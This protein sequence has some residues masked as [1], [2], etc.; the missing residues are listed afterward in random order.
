MEITGKMV[1]AKYVKILDMSIG[2]I[3]FQTDKRLAVGGR[4]TL[5]IES[6]GRILTAQGIVA[7]SL[8][9]QGI[10]DTQENIVPIYTAGMKF[11]DGT[12]EQVKEIANFIED[13]KRES[14]KQVDLFSPSGLRL[15]V[16]IH[17]EDPEMATLNLQE[18]YNVHNLSF[19]GMLI[20]SQN[21]LKIESKLPME[22]ILNE[23]KAIN[24]SGRV[25]SCRLITK[26]DIALYH[27]GIEFL[28]MSEKD[29]GILSEIIKLLDNMN[30]SSSS[31]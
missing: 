22:L 2:G 29:T 7:W 18:S 28:D 31:L 6:K 27:I 17:I 21:V 23:D 9:S 3:A 4:Y 10:R 20:E 14:D 24:V 25:V 1:L 30:E 8:L 15:H 19:G 16:R 11:M 26:E 13:H 5:T 12:S